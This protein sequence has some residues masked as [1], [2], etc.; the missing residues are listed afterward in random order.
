MSMT[1]CFIGVAVV[2]LLVILFFIFINYNRLVRSK[3]GCEEAWSNVDTELKR[4]YDLI[5]N[6][7]R[8]VK[9]YATHERELLEKITS[10]REQLQNMEGAG[11][12]AQRGEMEGLLGQFIGQLMVRMEAY[13]DLKANQNFLQLQ[14]ELVNTEDRIQAA[15]RLYNG[16]VRENNNLVEMFPSNIIANMFHFTKKEFFKVDDPQIYAAMQKAPEVNF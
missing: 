10:L 5:P 2:I 6:L 11:P 1:L 9:G 12:G 13:P 4:R 16:N 7:V 15:N 14:G 8:T 3:N